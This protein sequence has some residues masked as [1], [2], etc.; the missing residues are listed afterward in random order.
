MVEHWNAG[1]EIRPVEKM[2]YSNAPILQYPNATVM[3]KRLRIIIKGRVQGVGFRPT[4]YRLALQ[5]GLGGHVKNTSYGVVVE[6]EGEEDRL[7]EF[8]QR[9]Q[10][11]PPRQA[12]IDS[13]ETDKLPVAHTAT[14]EIVS[15]RR[16]GD[17][18]VGMPPDLA[19][20]DECREELFN[21]QDRR[22]G[23]PFLNCVNCGPRFTILRQLPY[24]RET[25][26]MSIFKQCSDC[27]S[28][29][30]DPSN[31]RF[32][33]QPNACSRCGPSLT[34]VDA[35]GRTMP[36]DP[37]KR[38]VE[39]LREGRIVAVK[40]LGGYHVC[41]D[42]TSETAIVLLRQRKKRP[43][44]AVAVMFRSIE[45]L[46]Q[47]CEVDDA[48]AEELMS[49]AC[50]V[51]VVR[52]MADTRMPKLISPDTS[53]IGAFLPYTPLH[54][55]LLSHISPLVM[56]S[57]NFAEEPIAKDEDELK[58]ILGS[59]AD[60]ALT[61]NRPVLR[62]CDDSVLRIV[63]GK[64]LFI[65]RSRGFVPD[66]IRLPLDG[67]S[68]FATGAELKNTLCVTRGN[69]AFVSQHI[70]DLGEYPSVRFFKEVAEDLPRLLEVAPEIVAHDLHPDYPN[71]HY[72]QSLDTPLKVA[73]QHHHAH[74]ASCMAEH[75][76][77]KPVIG[78]ALDGSGAGPDSTV[79][80]GE[81]FVADLRSYRR[82][83]HLKQYPLVGGDEAIRH[84]IRMALSYLVSEFGTEQDSFHHLL[85]G[86]ISQEAIAVLIEMIQKKIHSPLTSSCGRLFDAVAA[87]LG[88]CPAISYEGQAAIRLQNAAQSTTD[89]RYDFEIKQ[90]GGTDVVSFS[91][92][93]RSIVEDRREG[94]DIE[95]I[96]TMFHNTVAASCSEMCEHTRTRESI[97]Q[98]VLSGGVFQNDL[99]LRMLSHD[100]EKRGFEVYTH[101]KVP[102]NDA[103]IALGQA[104]V[105]LAKATQRV[106]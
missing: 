98:V 92:M 39:C 83:A 78:V 6:V 23:Y 35:Q 64:R 26:S 28:E 22:F 99:L 32:D 61:H 58:R 18:L 57:G 29:Y 49:C 86:D 102:P 73:V 44:K 60:L 47:H 16:S 3:K 37:I 10:A 48:E 11:Q 51:V 17:I 91:P 13:I 103:G 42:A 53:D 2:Q 105:A 84:P 38:T 15:S 68:V 1:T 94:R 72:A 59:I 75:C 21:P 5:F 20:C 66:A 55:L 43:D 95:I 80:G 31:R 101:Q 77:T 71:T 82:V 85:V 7:A 19:T 79:W 33:A 36:G 45:Q 4:V 14:F 104:V 69:L 52:R 34:L 76:L 100:L 63:S 62:R 30:V 65:R 74:I 41:C 88:L 50:P 8:V 27:H 81:F 90:N 25:T 24:D 12:Q 89:S 97:N 54:H 67:P 40:G 9:L 93:I 56:T 96:A 46:R 87:M 106:D 70:G